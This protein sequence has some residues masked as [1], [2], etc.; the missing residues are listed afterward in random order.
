[1]DVALYVGG[2]AAGQERCLRLTHACTAA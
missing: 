1:V 2:K